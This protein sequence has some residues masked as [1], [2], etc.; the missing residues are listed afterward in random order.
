MATV[1]IGGLTLNSFV[2]FR[3]PL[4]ARTD[5]DKVSGFIYV[6]IAYELVAPGDE[7]AYRNYFTSVQYLPPE[8]RRRSTVGTYLE[9]VLARPRA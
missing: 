8:R 4:E 9:D 7:D 2:T 3:L 5:S 1:P 6:G